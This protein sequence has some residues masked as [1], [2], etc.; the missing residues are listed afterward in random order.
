MPTS[1]HVPAVPHARPA[2]AERRVVARAEAEGIRLGSALTAREAPAFARAISRLLERAPA[3]IL[4]DLTDVR[5]TD[6]VGLAALLQSAERARERGVG[7]A[8]RAGRPVR[9]DLI[10]AHIVDVVPLVSPRPW[11]FEPPDDASAESLAREP[12][13]VAE[14]PALRLR[15]PEREDLALFQGWADDRELARLVGSE[16]LYRCRHLGAHD[17]GFGSELLHDPTSLTV[18]LESAGPPAAPAGFLRLYGIHLAQQF[19]FLE[20]AVTSREAT[21]RGLGIAASRLLV[22]Y[23][24]DVLRLRRIEAKAFAYNRPSVNALRR[25]GFQQ[26]GVLRHGVVED[27]TPWDVLVFSI[28]EPEMRAQRT[29]ERFRSMDLWRSE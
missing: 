9:Q 28:L 21:R 20:V 29:R 13:I 15:V 4:V 12:I 24:W 11:M 10:D 6:A 19:A 27:G 16:L 3:R 2:V 18:L 26:E 22:A 17:P 8:V 23:A 14:T 7:V 25:N 5:I 1:T